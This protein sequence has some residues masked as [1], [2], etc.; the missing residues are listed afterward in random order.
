MRQQ[1][2]VNP[3]FAASFRKNFASGKKVILVLPHVW[4]TTVP[5]N[6]E[7]IKMH[8]TNLKTDKQ[9]K[10]DPKHERQ[11]YLSFKFPC[12]GTSKV[13]SGDSFSQDTSQPN[14]TKRGNHTPGFGFSLP[15]FCFCG[16][17]FPTSDGLKVQFTHFNDHFS[18]VQGHTSASA[19]AWGAQVKAGSH[20]GHMDQLSVGRSKKKHGNSGG[21]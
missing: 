8:L 13:V 11:Y 19:C 18:H 16:A 5:M 3:L 10:Q 12:C 21:N 1:V 4:D 20:L 2:Q 15:G 6:T 17:T 7:E 9:N 14:T